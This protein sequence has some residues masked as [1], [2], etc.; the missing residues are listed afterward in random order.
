MLYYTSAF[1]PL[2]DMIERAIVNFHADGYVNP[3]AGY[4]QQFPTPPYRSDTFAAGISRSLPLLCVLAFI[5]SVST[6]VKG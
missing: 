2:Q 4:V 3:P 6:L 5:Y 1:V